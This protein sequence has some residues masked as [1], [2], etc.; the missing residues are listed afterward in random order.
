MHF[1]CYHRPE[2]KPHS[3]FLHII[4]TKHSQSPLGIFPSEYCAHSSFV[5]SPFERYPMIWFV[6]QSPYNFQTTIHSSPFHRTGS[7]PPD[8]RKK[9]GRFDQWL[10]TILHPG[11][12]SPRDPR[13]QRHHTGPRNH[14]GPARN[15]EPVRGKG[16]EFFAR[17]IGEQ[18]E[19]LYHTNHWKK[20]EIIPGRKQGMRISHSES[21]TSS[22]TII[23]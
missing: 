7:L 3:H 12:E 20:S 13:E 10:N 16:F 23:V 21:M 5:F 14:S 9:I 6:F 22:E 17:S 19:P 15:P 18:I 2:P 1:I 8:R 11:R 4:F